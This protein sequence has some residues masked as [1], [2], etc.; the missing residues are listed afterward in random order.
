METTKL[1]PHRVLEKA[2]PD[3]DQH[4]LMLTSGDFA[5]IIFSYDSVGFQEEKRENDDVLKIAFEYI[6]HEVPK[7]M[8]GYDKAAFEKELGDFLVELTYYGLERDFLGFTP[9]TDV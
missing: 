6:V 3:G 7:H 9:P 1:R 5:G 8:Q 4:A 2:T